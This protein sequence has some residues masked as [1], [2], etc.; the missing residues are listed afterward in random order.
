MVF[1]EG[2][3]FISWFAG[4]SPVSFNVGGFFPDPMMTTGARIFFLLAAESYF[5]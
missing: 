1:L 2:S 4:C 3:G 5:L